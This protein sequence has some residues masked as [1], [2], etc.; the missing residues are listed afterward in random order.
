MTPAEIR[1]KLARHSDEKSAEHVKRFF[2]TGPGE[3]G[4][5]DV[6]LGVKV[7]VIRKTVRKYGKN[8]SLENLEELLLSEIHELRY[9]ALVEMVNRFSHKNTARKG[10]KAIFDLYMKNRDRVNNWDLVDVSAPRIAG[11]WLFANDR[12]ILWEL[13]RSEGL[14]NRRIAV[15]ATLYFIKNHEFDP[16][17]S[18]ARILIDD[19]EDLIHKAVGWMLREVGKINF[20]VQEKFMQATYRSMHRT[21]LRYAIEKYPEPLRQAYLHG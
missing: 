3:Y 19:K 12:S 14:W 10:R 17:L 5:G 4:E 18:I 21:M 8:L 6:F 20:A 13:A 1:D 9:F 16:T 15:V 2:K 7:P 11:A